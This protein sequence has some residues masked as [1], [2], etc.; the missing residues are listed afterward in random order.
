M[1]QN[2]ALRYVEAGSATLDAHELER[3]LEEFKIEIAR[4][5]RTASARVIELGYGRG[6]FLD[7]AKARGCTVT[8]TEINPVLH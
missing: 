5:G 3:L 8:G 2:D 7:W 1:T 6:H 4:A